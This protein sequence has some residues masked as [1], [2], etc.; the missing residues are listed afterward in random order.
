MMHSECDDF[1]H[2]R[3][4]T[5][6][7]SCKRQNTVWCE[8]ATGKC[9]CYPGW[10]GRDCNEGMRPSSLENEGGGGGYPLINV[11]VGHNHRQSKESQM[12]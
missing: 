3:D 9:H 12:S 7:C 2:G 5:E 6:Q 8:S 11:C 1:L 4:C 10:R